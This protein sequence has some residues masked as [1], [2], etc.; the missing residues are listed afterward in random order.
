[1]RYNGD[2]IPECHEEKETCMSL[3]SLQQGIEAV[4]K[5]SHAEGALLLQNALKDTTLP[6]NLRATA[7]MWLAVTNDDRQFRINCYRQA[8]QADPHNKQASEGLSTLLA[9]QLPETS[10]LTTPVPAVKPVNPPPTAPLPGTQPL[11]PPPTAPS[12]HTGNTPTAPYPATQYAPTAPNVGYGQP[13]SAPDIPPNYG[14]A[15]THQTQSMPSIQPQPNIQFPI[16]TGYP[17]EPGSTTGTMA[18]VAPKMVIQGAQRSVGILGGPNGRGTGFFVTREGLIATT[19]YVVGGL[20]DVEV[21]LLSQQSLPGRVVRAFPEYDLA[22]IQVNANVT[23]LMSPSHNP[24]IPDNTPLLIVSHAGEV[25]RTTRRETRQEIPMYWF[26]TL[27]KQLHDA[28]GSPVFD[29]L[30]FLVGMMTRNASRNSG[31]LYGLHISMIYKCVDQHTHELQQLSGRGVYCNHCGNLS[32]AGVFNAFYCERC[33]ATLPPALA[34]DR[35]PQPNMGA[36]YGE[37]MNQPCPHCRSTVGYAHG[38]CLRC[39]RDVSSNRPK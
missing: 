6:G 37:N 28:G 20:E 34:I 13:T 27:E 15:P 7:W 19:R 16:G 29:N 21:Q 1:M 35:Y 5:G 11:N 26:P 30:Q 2:T 3:R 17:P 8:F 24:I 12:I 39:G 9:A 10:T 36:L 18:A 38:V 25:Q 4:Q 33:G 31:F 23:H 14:Q 32:R 22:L